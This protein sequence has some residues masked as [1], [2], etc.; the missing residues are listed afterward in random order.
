MNIAKTLGLIPK[1]GNME[2]YS[3]YSKADFNS[4]IILLPEGI[5]PL[6][7]VKQDLTKLEQAEKE[8][9]AKIAR[10]QERLLVLSQELTTNRDAINELMAVFEKS[11]NQF[12]PANAEGATRSIVTSR[13]NTRSGFTLTAQDIN[14]LGSET[15]AVIEKIGLD[16]ANID[17]A[18]ATSLIE[19]QSSQI[20]NKLYASRSSMKYMVKIGNNL[21]PSDTLLGDMPTEIGEVTIITPGACP[22]APIVA[23]T[24]QVTV[25]ATHG[26]ARVLGIADLM[27]VEQELLRYELGEIAHIENVLKSE[28][29]ERTFRT[30]TTTEQ[31]T[32]TETEVTDEKTKDLSSAERFELQTESEKVINEDTSTEAGVTVNASY[33]PSVDV[34]ANFNYT[35]NSSR[36]ESNR[37]SA[38]FARD[39]TTRATSKIQKRTLERRFFKTVS[40]IEETNKHGFDNK[41]G[42]ENISGVYRFVDKIYHAQIVNYG[43]RLML[44]FV[45][46]EPAAFLRYAMTRQPTEG[47]TQVKPEQPGYCKNNNFVAL[48]PQDITPDNYLYWTSKYL[49]EDIST[50][51]QQNIILSIPL[52][53]ETQIQT[54][55]ATKSISVDVPD[56]YKPLKARSLRQFASGVDPGTP[57]FLKVFI[58]DITV[59][60]TEV[61][62]VN[63]YFGSGN[64]EKI[65]IT[66]LT[67]DAISYM[68]TINIFCVLTLEKFQEWQ[69]NTYNSI[70]NAYNDQKSRYE[71]AM[72]AARIRAGY[73]QIGGTNP[74]MNRECEKTELKKGCIS[75]LTAQNFETFDAMRR[76]VA[77]HG[78]PEIAY[79]DAKAEGRY[80][81]FFENAFEWKNMTYVFYSYFWGKKE[82]WVTIS[83][84]VDDDPLYTKFLQAGAARVQVP[85]RPGFEISM[86]HYLQ[87]G[88][89]WQGEGTIVNTEDGITDPLYLSVLDELK[90]QLGN[91]NIEGLGRLT[92]KKDDVKV[93]GEGTRFYEEDENKRIIIKGKTYVMKQVVSPTEIQLA[94]KFQGDDGSD[95]RYSLGVKLVGEPWEVKLPTDLVTIDSNFINKIQDTLEI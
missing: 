85:I 66:L 16:A 49:A 41:L 52:T 55:T 23:E 59:E 74:F 7:N 30:A 47:V 76:N 62:G 57:D 95:V 40:E 54:A 34:T 83:Q 13:E 6:P 24:D 70:I 26:E 12:P 58:G 82:D 67:A 46:P 56:G 72:E 35:N 17:V 93:I 43:K 90:E 11:S 28:V 78:Y 63:H 29:K 3:E 25:P 36:Q 48:Q 61:D 37:A 68:V 77:P 27:V 10:S 4:Q 64:W 45:V 84:I 1:L 18:L 19:K 88:T 33:G 60:T 50:P 14:S 73:S 80:I 91:Q 69:I 53:S 32:L 20:S 22:P 31:S 92:V 44:E 94:E 71:N 81:Q 42:E 15:K 87:L 65:G 51:P 86:G 79:A 5:F 39:T 38:N 9:L 89:I 8:R 75:L 2:R 21:I